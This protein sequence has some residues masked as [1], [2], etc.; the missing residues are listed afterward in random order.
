MGTRRFFATTSRG[1]EDV[2]AEEIRALGGREA[3]TAAGGV[4]FTGEPALGYRANLWLRTANRVLLHL[5]DFHAPTPAAL[6]EGVAAIPWPEIFPVR[7][8]F[9]VDATVRDG[10]VTHSH[11]AAQKTKDAVVDRFRDSQGVRP[12]VNLLS[13]DIRINIRIV[14]DACTLSLDLSGESLNR[15]GYRADPEE[16]SLRETLAAG[17]VLLTGWEGRTP[18]VDPVC[19][20]GTIPIEAALFATNTAPGLRRSGFAFQ[21]LS[22]YDRNLWDSLVTEAKEKRSPS[23]AARIEGSDLSPEAIRSAQRNAGRAGVSA[24]AALHT[25][26]IKEFSPSGPPGII[27]CNPPYGVRMRPGP[28]EEIFYRAL[29]HVFKKRCAGW[30]AYILSGDPDATRHIGLKAS[31]KFPLMNGP[32]DCRLLKYEL[33]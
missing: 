11:F 28:G 24:V 20:A 1:L 22:D 10:G 8:T 12:D 13:P 5:S 15:R 30:T 32:I 31:R 6:Y 18:L 17:M 27:L 23:A 25:R 19:G 2:L 9:V 16:A 4:S 7:K 33:Y 3:R 29:G 26:D 21:H 14:R